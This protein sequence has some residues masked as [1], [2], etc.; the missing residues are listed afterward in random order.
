MQKTQTVDALVVSGLDE[1]RRMSDAIG[2]ALAL[3][4]ELLHA[5]EEPSPRE[6]E[7]VF[8]EIG[9]LARTALRALRASRT[10]LDA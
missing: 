6:M 7:D 1:A 8:R 5:S 3:L 4:D 10:E 9:D 2:V